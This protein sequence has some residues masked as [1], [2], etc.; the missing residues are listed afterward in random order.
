MDR[1]FKVHVN[2]KAVS[3]GIASPKWKNLQ[4]APLICEV[5]I[6]GETY[7]PTRVQIVGNNGERLILL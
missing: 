1:F 7:Q 3:I 5:Q 4:L 6:N 2:E